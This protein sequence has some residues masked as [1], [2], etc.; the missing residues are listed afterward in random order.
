METGLRGWADRIRTQKCR[1]KISPWKVA[2]I[3]RNPP[4]FRPQRQFAFELRDWG[5]R[6]SGLWKRPS[7]PL[8][9]KLFFTASPSRLRSPQ[10]RE[11][12]MS[13]ITTIGLAIEAGRR[14]T[15]KALD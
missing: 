10:E 7:H 6:S 11:P 13:E 9:H 8:T 5:V 1:H 14:T 12:S 3:S 2:E 15:S 4:E